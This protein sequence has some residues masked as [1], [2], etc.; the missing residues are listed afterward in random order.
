[1]LARDNLLSI[2]NVIAA[3]FTKNK[4]RKFVFP[5]Y[6]AKARILQQFLPFLLYFLKIKM[7]LESN[8]SFPVPFCA[9]C[10][11]FVKERHADRP[12]P[13]VGTDD[14]AERQNAA[15]HIKIAAQII[16][17]LQIV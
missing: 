1:M 4:R 15:L 5:N 14:A 8:F 3:V 13:R 12:R 16:Q 11:L 17:I 10:F 7:A 9:G 6:N 2:L